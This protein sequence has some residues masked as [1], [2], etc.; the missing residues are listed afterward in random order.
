MQAV[1]C[2]GLLA[3][4]VPAGMHC[5]LQICFVGSPLQAGARGA[6]EGGEA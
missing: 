3:Q 4:H 1:P 6:Q 5:P 2:L